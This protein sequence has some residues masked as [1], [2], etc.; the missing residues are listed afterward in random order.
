MLKWNNRYKNY[1][2]DK[3]Y[4]FTKKD[5]EF[6]VKIEDLQTGSRVLIDVECDY[7]KTKYNIPYCKY[8]MSVKN[9]VN[10]DCCFK[11]LYLKVKEVNLI[12]Y[13]VQNVFQLEDVKNKIKN[14]NLQKYG[15]ENYAKT[16]EC[17]KK[18]KTTNLS[19]YGQ[20]YYTQTEE[21]KKR[22]KNTCLEKY[23][24]ESHTKNE[25][26]KEKIYKTNIERYGVKYLMQNEK[27]KNKIKNT[28]MIK[29]GG[30]SPSSSIIIRNKIKRT[31]LKKYGVEC[32]T[33]TE[34]FKSKYKNTCQKK[35]GVD[36]VSQIQEVKE[37]K[38]KSF[39]KN[40]TISTSS[41]QIEVFNLLKN[42]NYNVELNYP[43]SLCSLDVALFIN[44]IKINIEYD[45]WYWH[46]PKKDRKRDEFLK[47]QGWKIFR[48]KSSH[49]V[50]SLEQI[51]EGIFKLVNSDRSFTQIYLDD[52]NEGV[53]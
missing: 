41:Q 47:S 11:C 46:N 10:K 39:Y 5:N 15:V 16:E 38:N 45:G 6:E 43:V 48:I 19:K 31:N 22:Y 2:I 42:D 21:Y 26:V 35:Y 33:Q 44:N 12:K 13:G 9:L 27:I 29:Y 28:N 52:W 7:C 24:Y 40:G 34:E 18:T 20:E 3:N 32:Y 37:K 8:I 36:N 51:K 23:G 1:Y 50:P 14:T 4:V 49:K 53:K 30:N 25:E 17:K